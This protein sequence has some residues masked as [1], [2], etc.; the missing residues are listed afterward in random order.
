MKIYILTTSH[1][2]LF[3]FKATFDKYSNVEVVLS[4]FKTFMKLN[5]NIECI[6][7]PANSYGIM[8]GGYDSAISDF[9]GWDF[10]EKVKQYIKDNYYIQNSIFTPTRTIKNKHGY[11]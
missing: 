1:L 5:P 6:V 3:M 10:Q 7:S 11:M 8:N 9:L 4:D 2:E